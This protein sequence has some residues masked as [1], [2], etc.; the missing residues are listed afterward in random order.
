[1]SEEGSDEVWRTRSGCCRGEVELWTYADDEV[2][3]VY[4]LIVENCIEDG[5]AEFAGCA[6]EC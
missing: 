6:G 5:G 1:L 2:F 4:E 3:W